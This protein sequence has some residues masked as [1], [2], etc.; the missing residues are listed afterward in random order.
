MKKYIIY[1]DGFNLYHRRIKNIK[2]K[3]LDLKALAQSFNFKD[4]EISKIKYFTAEVIATED[5]RTIKE[6]QDFYLRALR[7]IPEIE[8]H[9][10]KFKRRTV[11]GRLLAKGNS[12]HK[13]IV[14]IEKFEE[15][16]SDVNIAT[17]ML[18]D[19]FQKE[20]EIPVLVSNDSDLSEPLKYIKTILKMPVGLVTPATFFMAELKRYSSFR[21]K[22]SDTQLESSQFPHTLKDNKSEISCPKKW[23]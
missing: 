17:F 15:K 13:K 16:G 8:I 7:T 22:I 14:E 19:C 2:Y 18:V 23:C 6:R 5:D 20:C 11:K 1:V 3:W 4:C 9:F 10:G 12:L 21:R